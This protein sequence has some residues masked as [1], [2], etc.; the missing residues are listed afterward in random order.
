MYKARTITDDRDLYSA[1]YFREHYEHDPKREAM[2]QQE[3]DRI[4]AYFPDGGTILD[5]GCGVGGFLQSFDDRWQKY[6][7]EPSEFASD[8]A[9]GRGI[10]IMQSVQIA[11]FDTFDVVVFRGTLQHINFPMAAL[12]HAYQALKPGGLLAVL[13]TPDTDGLVYKIWGR[14]PAL[15]APRN[16]ILF[17]RRELVNI[18]ERFGYQDIRVLH[19][20]LGTP[21]ASPVKDF[22]KFA[23]SLVFGWR[24]FAFPGSMMEVYAVKK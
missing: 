10:A 6:G 16:W 15:D 7:V 24:K 8:R 14:L 17:G 19:P 1:E 2:Y 12:T 9:R 11:D 13:A 20:Y 5:I 23:V 18:L 3:R 21:Y 4:T 22:C